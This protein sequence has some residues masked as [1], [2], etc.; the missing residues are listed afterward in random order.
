MSMNKAMHKMQS[1]EF[2]LHSYIYIN[3][4]VTGIN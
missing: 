3:A 1:F 2:L 4:V